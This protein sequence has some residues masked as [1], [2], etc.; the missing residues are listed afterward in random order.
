MSGPD[1][2]NLRGN[3]DQHAP[4]LL[5]YAQLLT[6]DRARAAHVVQQTL[7]R[8]GRDPEVADSPARSARAWLFSNARKM[9]VDDRRDTDI[10]NEIGAV[11]SVWP[12]RAAP[13]EI[14]AAVDRLLLAD[15]LAQL[16]AEDRAVLRYAYYER[17]T[18]AQIAADLGIAEGAVK[19][20]LHG[21]LR[22]LWPQL[23][24]MGVAN[25]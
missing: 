13:K 21:A 4:A 17:R 16:P 22:T 11:G 24:E 7:L 25:C 23:R 5:R 14:N 18:T 2:G 20:R 19:S 8:A 1:S 10:S 9:L 12:D 6:S 15:A 3:H